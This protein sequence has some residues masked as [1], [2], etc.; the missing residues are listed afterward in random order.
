MEF[1]KIIIENPGSIRVGKYQ[2][3]EGGE[4]DPRNKALMKMFNLIDI[5]ERAGSGIPE[6]FNVWEQENFEEPV[7]EERLDDVERTCLY[8]PLKKKAT[9]KNDDKKTTIKGDDKKATV[10]TQAQTETI[11]NFM[12]SKK[13]Y[14]SRDIMIALGLKETRTKELLK[15]LISMDKIEDNGANKNRTYRKKQ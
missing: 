5:G 11:L 12:D 15:L 4:S 3:R 6:L 8:L 10:K 1:D 7:I 9:I 14:K 2:M 13:W